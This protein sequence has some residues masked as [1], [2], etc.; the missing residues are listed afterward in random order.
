MSVQPYSE[1]LEDDHWFD[2][3]A[4]A[5]MYRGE[6][7]KTFENPNTGEPVRFLYR[8]ID[9]GTLLELTDIALFSMEDRSVDDADVV[10]EEPLTRDDL[11]TREFRAFKIR[12]T[13]RL[14]VLHKCI[15]KPSFKTLDQVKRLPMEWQEEL[16][17]IIMKNVN[18]GENLSGK[19]FPRS[20]STQ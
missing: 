2:P 16:Y 10:V 14:E 4:S 1:R 6:Y 5:E 9:P 18:G 3:D 20:G 11:I 8:R 19:R 7:V 13:H 12:T 15:V 17:H